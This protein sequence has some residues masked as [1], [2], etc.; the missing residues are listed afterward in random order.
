MNSF[1]A[2]FGMLSPAI[3]N[4]GGSS[5]V[6]GENKQSL[7]ERRHDKESKLEKKL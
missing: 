4:V 5:E 7:E 6:V 3:P 2:F 1:N